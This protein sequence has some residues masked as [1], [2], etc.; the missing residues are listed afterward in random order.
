M[1]IAVIAAFVASIASVNAWGSLGHS[2]TG[3][4]AQKV[5]CPTY[6]RNLKLIEYCVPA[7]P[8]P[9]QQCHPDGL[10]FV[11]SQYSGSLAGN[12]ANWADTTARTL[13]PES[14]AWHYVDMMAAV[15]KSCGYVQSDCVGRSCIIAAITDQTKILLDAKCAPS[16]ETTQA[17]QFLAHFLGDITQ[18]LHNWYSTATVEGTTYNGQQSNFHKIHDTNI[19]VSYA[20]ENGLSGTDAAGL[21]QLLDSKYASK[22]SE[23][24][25]ATFIDLT[26]VDSANNL[27]GAI[28]MATDSNALDCSES[29]FWGLFDQDPNQDFSGAYY[30]ATKD[31]LAEQI[32]KGG[33]RSA[34]WMN[35]IADACAGT[36]PDPN[37][38]TTT[39]AA[40]PDPTSTGAATTCA[41]SECE[42]GARL[43]RTCSPCAALVG[44]QDSYCTRNSWDDICVNIAVDACGLQC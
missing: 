10:N 37:P 41:H 27:L 13:I 8:V 17:V 40:Q 39:T 6:K 26:S 12:T 14:A 43:K 2:T 19:P 25:S 42:V 33:Y 20:T 22:M 29:A 15:P 28:A 31:F 1:Q 18:P 23:Y 11:E 34:A 32:A 24:T 5:R 3:T 7:L 38:A 9:Q 44:K 30:D 21:A 4:I 16:T 36:T 35:A